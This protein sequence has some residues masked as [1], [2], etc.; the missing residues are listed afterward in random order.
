MVQPIDISDPAF[1]PPER[2]TGDELTDFIN[3]AVAAGFSFRVAQWLADKV[4]NQG[5]VRFEDIL[6]LAVLFPV[7]SQMDTPQLS[8]LVTNLPSVFGTLG[9]SSIDELEGLPIDD[10]VRLQISET[11]GEL[12]AQPEL[13]REEQRQR[14]AAAQIPASQD[15]LNMLE[16]AR[17]FGL[18]VSS[19]EAATRQPQINRPSDDVLIGLV[20]QAISAGHTGRAIGRIGE[21]RRMAEQIQKVLPGEFEAFKATFKEDIDPARSLLAGPDVGFLEWAT[22]R[23][24]FGA[25]FKRASERRGRWEQLRGQRRTAI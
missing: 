1:Q 6:E 22:N 7:I 17:G 18:D 16:T 2:T 4:I 20:R 8:T 15:L 12:A 13:A 19:I 5:D 11:L 21:T 3:D 9:I 23:P 14:V 24:E 25:L 10:R